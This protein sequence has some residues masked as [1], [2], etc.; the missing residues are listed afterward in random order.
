MRDLYKHLGIPPAASAEQIRSAID[1]AD[2]GTLSNAAKHVL[3]HPRRRPVYDRNHRLLTTIGHL[4][5]RLALGMR[6]F[7]SH[8]HFH[9]FTQPFGAAGP[10]SA[11]GN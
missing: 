10:E 3:L 11:D 8:G 9:D 6:P 2:P 5:G 7:W 1:A 4:R